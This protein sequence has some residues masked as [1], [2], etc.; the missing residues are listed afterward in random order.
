VSFTALG[1]TSQKLGQQC[2]DTTLS[3]STTG[4]WE[5]IDP[6]GEL[7]PGETI[8]KLYYCKRLDGY[9]TIPGASLFKVLSDRCSLH[10]TD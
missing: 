6:E 8:V 9:V 5:F 4:K 7:I 1:R 10:P 2:F 3:K